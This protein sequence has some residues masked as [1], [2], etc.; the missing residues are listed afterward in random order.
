MN[1]DGPETTLETSVVSVA[2]DPIAQQKSAIK[3]ALKKQ[4]KA[5]TAEKYDF[6]MDFD[7]N[8]E[9]ICLFENC[10]V[11]YASLSWKKTFEYGSFVKIFSRLFD[12]LCQQ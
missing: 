7:Q 2:V 9:G 1:D 12:F 8:W 4:R 10:S 6:K 3:Q 5:E 11:C